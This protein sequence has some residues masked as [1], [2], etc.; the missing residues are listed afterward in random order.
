M[1]SQKNYVNLVHG[2]C[3][4]RIYKIEN[5]FYTYTVSREQITPFTS[6]KINEI[7]NVVLKKLEDEPIQ[8]ELMFGY[9]AGSLSRNK[10]RKLKLLLSNGLVDVDFKNISLWVSLLI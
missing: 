4:T 10:K 8:V 1:T 2:I 3:N 7:V 5:E 6:T 9:K